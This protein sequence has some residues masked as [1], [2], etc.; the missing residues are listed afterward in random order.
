MP[1][2]TTKPRP[3]GEAPVVDRDQCLGGARSCL[4]TDRE[5]REKAQDPDHDERGLHHPGG[6]VAQSTDF[7]LP[8][9]D[10]EQHDRGRD[11]GEQKDQFEERAPFDTRLRA[12]EDELRILENVSEP[13]VQGGRRNRGK[14][15]DREPHTCPKSGSTRG[16]H[17]GILFPVADARP[18]LPSEAPV[19]TNRGLRFFLRRRW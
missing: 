3:E 8:L 16:G 15:R 10:R 9:Q 14:E 4:V 6:D 17:L 12:A 11:V 5:D 7:P 19:P 2:P 18:S 13:A 1:T